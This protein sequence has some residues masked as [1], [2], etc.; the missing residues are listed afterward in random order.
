M[1]AAVS[2]VMGI[3]FVAAILLTSTVPR[4]IRPGRT[5]FRAPVGRRS[6]TAV[7]VGSAIVALIAV[8]ARASHGPIVWGHVATAVLVLGAVVVAALPP[9]GTPRRRP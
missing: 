9:E 5:W 4:L 3:G 6:A 7:F 2:P 8:T 1:D